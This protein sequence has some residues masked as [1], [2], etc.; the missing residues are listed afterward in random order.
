MLESMFRSARVK[1]TVFY[2]II[3]V[4]FSFAMSITIRIVAER[5]LI[6]SNSVQRSEVREMV[7]RY[8][9]LLW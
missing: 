3:I 4:L 9:R 8:F 7:V 1:L 2:L 6:H 5:E